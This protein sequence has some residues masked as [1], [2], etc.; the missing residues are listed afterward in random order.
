MYNM[1]CWV[2][3]HRASLL[4]S[5]KTS[6]PPLC[7]LPPLNSRQDAKPISGQLTINDQSISTLVYSRSTAISP[8]VFR[9][10]DGISYSV[11]EAWYDAVNNAEL[12]FENLEK[13][14]G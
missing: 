3:C 8:I 12:V 13:V 9:E 11:L 1:E 6:E 2:P 7:R 10:G 14:D 5:R 4:I